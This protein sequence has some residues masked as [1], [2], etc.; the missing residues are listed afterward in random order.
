MCTLNLFEKVRCA[1]FPELKVNKIRRLAVLLHR[2]H[3]P[4]T[5]IRF[6]INIFLYFISLKFF[7]LVIFLLYFHLVGLAKLCKMAQANS[8][9][10][11][12]IML[13]FTCKRRK[14]HWSPS[15]SSLLLMLL[16]LM[17]LQCFY[18]VLG[19]I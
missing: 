11:P 9:I 16:V 7:L 1:H 8:C 4:L 14:L 13:V 12:E 17:L 19:V 18:F 5:F 10:T 6:F 15:S 2:F 3:N